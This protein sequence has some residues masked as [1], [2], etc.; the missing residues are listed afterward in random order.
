[1]EDLN[2]GPVE[3]FR[4]FIFF[5]IISILLFLLFRE[6][7]CW[8]WKINKRISMAEKQ[9]VLLEKILT[10]LKSVSPNPNPNQNDLVASETRVIDDKITDFYQD[11]YDSLSPKE[12]KE[13]DK[14]IKH[15]LRI[16]EKLVI[17]KTTRDINR[18]SLKEWKEICDKYED[19]N[20]IIIWE[21][22]V[23]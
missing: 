5:V 21:R 17:N 3:F 16:G 19:E 1:M 15:G 18:F 23:N 10:H 11:V 20:W 12:Q 13:A 8:Y 14:Y 2:L 7:F 22:K 9:I 6:I 4:F